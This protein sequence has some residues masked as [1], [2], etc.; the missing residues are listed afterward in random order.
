MDELREA[1]AL[2]GRGMGVVFLAL[3][4]LLLLMLGLRRLLSE[5]QFSPPLASPAG[6]APAAETT[7][8]AP[9]YLRSHASAES[10]G[11]ADAAAS[12]PPA[13][14]AATQAPVTTTVAAPP[15]PALPPTDDE[16]EQVA[17]L[18]AAMAM[19]MDAE[20]EAWPVRLPLPVRASA[21][22]R[23]QGRLDLM[24]GQGR[25]LAGWRR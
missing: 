1:L 6:V 20:F 23:Y 22:W 13:A 16:L 9:V 17:V 5:R 3:T 14:P 19:A 24:Q 18:A 4:L 25:P 2:A 8:D 12:T 10:Q 11:P 21:V 7:G 15:A